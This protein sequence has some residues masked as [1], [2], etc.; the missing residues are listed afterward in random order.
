MLTY[1]VL[2]TFPFREALVSALVPLPGSVHSWLRACVSPRLDSPSQVVQRPSHCLTWTF[3][4]CLSPKVSTTLSTAVPPCLHMLVCGGSLDGVTILALVV[5]QLVILATHILACSMMLL[6]GIL[7]HC[8]SSGLREQW[9]RR[10][11][12]PLDAAAQWACDPWVFN[13]SSSHNSVA[14]VVAHISFVGQVC[15]RFLSAACCGFSFLVCHS[16]PA[17]LPAF[18]VRGSQQLVVGFFSVCSHS[19]LSGVLVVVLL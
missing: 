18:P 4:C 19:A 10:V 13:A 12:V 3:V 5:V 9:C 1:A 6:K 11:S 16:L 2:L 14:T 15:E 17:L 7:A 8:L